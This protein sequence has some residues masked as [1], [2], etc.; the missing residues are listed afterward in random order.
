MKKRV[1][2]NK[3]VKDFF[4]IQNMKLKLLQFYS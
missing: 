3:I 4:K 2:I 1:F